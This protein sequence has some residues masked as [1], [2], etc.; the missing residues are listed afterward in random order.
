MWLISDVWLKYLDDLIE[1]SPK[2][3]TLDLF[4]EILERFDQ[5]E[6]DYICGWSIT[7]VA[8][9]QACAILLRHIDFVLQCSRSNSQGSDDTLSVDTDLASFLTENSTRSIV[10][11]VVQRGEGLMSESHL[12]WQP[13]LA[14]E[15]TF[16]S[17][18]G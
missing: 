6:R 14:W 13:W 5:A 7:N 10:Q 9:V 11:G 8:E 3:L 15:M 17:S 16:I 18:D 4:V 2:P 1:S 12:L